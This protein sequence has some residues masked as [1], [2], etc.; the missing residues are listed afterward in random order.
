[1]E[2]ASFKFLC[3][4]KMMRSPSQYPKEICTVVNPR[5][6]FEKHRLVPSSP[7]TKRYK[8]SDDEMIAWTVEDNNEWKSIFDFA[9][10]CI[11]KTVLHNIGLSM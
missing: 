2:H 9:G 11:P 1:M 7:D 6:A 4:I 5:G 3:R 8:L 10:V